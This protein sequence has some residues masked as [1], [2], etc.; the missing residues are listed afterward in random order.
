MKVSRVFIVDDHQIMVD[1]IKSLL[2]LSNDYEVVGTTT[3]SATALKLIT[4]S[5]TD[6]V[7]TDIEMKEL[8]GIELTKQ[9][10][11]YNIGIKVLALSM[12]GDR[13]TIN[14]MIGAGVDGYILKNTGLEELLA[15]LESIKEGNVFFSKE[16][17]K[18]MLNAIKDMKNPLENKQ[19]HLTPRE[20][21]IIQLI[22]QELSNAEIG[23]RLFISER[24]V[25]THR[26]NIF[27]KTDK[28]SVAGLIIYAMENQLVK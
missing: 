1:G 14:E 2:E 24:T 15:A 26:K 20:I 25:E 28:K 7:I 6:I 17:T 11:A 23:N 12:Y 16:I 22:A 9:I 18:E 4:D 5:K 27:R 13:N 21:E 3:Q 8:S 19:V 10:K